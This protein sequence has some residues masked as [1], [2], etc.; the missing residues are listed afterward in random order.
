M[1]RII[2][3]TLIFLVAGIASAQD[4][5]LFAGYRVLDMS[6]PYNSDTIYWPTEDDFQL[7]PEFSG[8][9]DGGYWYSS[10]TLTTAEHGGTHVDA[11]IHFAEGQTTMDELPLERLMGAVA[12]VD[13]SEGAT[14]NVDYQ[15]S[16]AD[17]EAWEARHGRLPPGI[18]VLLRTGYG[19]YWPD[20]LKYMGT[21]ERGAGAVPKLHFPGLHPDTARWLVAERN[22][23]AIGLDTPSI[24]YGQS[25]LFES[26][27]VL[28]A[29]NIPAF[30]NVANL[31]QLPATG[32]YVIALP[33]KIEGGSGGPLRIIGLVP[34]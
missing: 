29:E 7:N 33:M 18:I 30:E 25:S 12:V 1:L 28:F 4:M 16:V 3:L 8:I 19:Q 20:R 24:D 22:V 10:N 34:E 23:N 2:F 21:D 5:D 13:V 11:P 14:D 15:V 6:Y 27:R 26:H 32:A 17:I 31:D 9:T